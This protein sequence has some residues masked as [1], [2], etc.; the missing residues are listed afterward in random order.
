[1][2]VDDDGDLSE[3]FDKLD[4]YLSGEDEGDIAIGILRERGIEIPEDDSQLDDAA[5]HAKLWEVIEG[6][7]AIGMFIDSTDHMSDRELYRYL[8]SDALQE[9]VLLPGAMAGLWQISPIGGGSEEDNEIYLR[10]YADD[11]TRLRWQKD[12]GRAIPSKEKTPYD[13]DRLLPNGEARL[14]GREH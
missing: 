12:F 6:M 3:H 1:M 2:R 8:V 9:G 7:A 14:L 10:Y 13:R 4:R 11:E 5:L